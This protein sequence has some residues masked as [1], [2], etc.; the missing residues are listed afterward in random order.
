MKLKKLTKINLKKAE[1]QMKNILLK[2]VRFIDDTVH[3][4]LLTDGKIAAIDSN[5]TEIT[6]DEIIEPEQDTYISAGWIDIHTHSFNKFELYGDD[7]D[8]VGYQTGVTTV[9]DAGTSGSDNIAEFYDEVKDKRTRVFAMLNIAKPGIYAQYE[10]SDLAN[11]DIAK[12][13]ETTKIYKD[14][15][16]GVK[17]R[18]SSSVVGEN[19]VKP[20]EL[21]ILAAEETELPIMVHIGNAPPKLKD[22]FAYLRPNDIVTHIFNPK[23]DG[24]LDENGKVRPFVFEGMERGILYDVGHGTDSF[25]FK[26]YEEATKQ[27][28]QFSTISSD[29]YRRNRANGPVYDLATTM[30]KFLLLGMDKIEIINK[31][32][33]NAAVAFHLTGLGEIKVGNT[34]DFTFFKII[35]GEKELVDSTG[36]KRMTQQYFQP[37]AVYLKNEFINISTNEEG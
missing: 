15:I 8:K 11:I 21:A 19:D 34:A 14:F 5:L 1:N 13:V 28:V 4:I 27:G 18:M 10:L 17:A 9:V 30:S 7:C 32:T 37:V 31:V 24:I 22:V 29:I 16:V 3:H 35:N 20:L 6:A 12:F 2:N 26:T 36:E 23:P 25:G 33:K